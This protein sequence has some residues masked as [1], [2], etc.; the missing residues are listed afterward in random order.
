[1]KP[2][3]ITE[4]LSLEMIGFSG[5]AL[6]KDYAGTAFKLMDKMW[7]VVKSNNLKNKG[8]NIWV[9]EDGEK[10]FV[11]VE[12]VDVPDSDTGLEQKNITLSKYAFYRHVG[13]YHLIK[14]AG[15]SMINE[16][17]SQGHDI[18]SPYIE[19]YGHWTNDE[20]KLETDLI[21]SLQ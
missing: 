4:P 19:I 17:K 10:V 16:L 8:R 7:Q 14:Q 11:G 2:E 20:S 12:F 6:N 9:Y 15:Q 5:I 1:M 21:I 13:P 18:K 3:I